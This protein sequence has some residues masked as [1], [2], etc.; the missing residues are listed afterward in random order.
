MRIIP[1]LPITLNEIAFALND[2][3]KIREHKIIKAIT[4]DSR[5]AECGDLFVALDGDSTSGENFTEDA[6]KKGAYII[7]A[8]NP[9][10]D[11]KVIDTSL[12]LL[13]I[14][15]YYKSKFRICQ[16]VFEKF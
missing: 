5:K 9:C 14:A 1:T 3:G 10:S 4:T 6:R 11:F 12:A 13:R 7:S 16:G 8:K 15:S 2:T